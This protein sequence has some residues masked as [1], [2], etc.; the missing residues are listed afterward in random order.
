MSRIQ[1]ILKKAE[2][3]GDVHRTRGLATNE[4]PAGGRTA[5][6]SAGA[7]ASA[8]QTPAAWPPAPAPRDAVPVTKVRQAEGSLEARLVAAHASQS[9][10]AEQ[11][12]SLRTR[13][14]AAE[15]GHAQRVIIVTSPNTGDGKSLTAANLALTMAQEFQQRVLLLD[16]DLRRPSIHH[17]F[18]I[19]ETPGLSDVLMGG[20]TV[21]DALV[22]LPEHH[23]MV[24]PSGLVPVHP[25]ELLGSAGMRRVIDTLRTRFDRI[26]LDMPPVAPLADVSI[27]SGM[28][29]GILMIVR[30]GVTPKPAI[31]RA[32]A[33]LE[34]SKVLGL[35]LNDAGASGRY[36]YDDYDYGGY[37]AG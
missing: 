35:V 18:G 26:I 32:L 33:G 12:R 31:E 15:N 3:E 16:A 10:A 24:L 23:L 14:K 30:A 2:R 9:L 13:I 1:E 37:V 22:E 29:D 4:P 36:G 17:M 6:P 34:M 21:E 20:S 27:A 25:A 7:S 5:S 19:N 28:V 8:I 11:F